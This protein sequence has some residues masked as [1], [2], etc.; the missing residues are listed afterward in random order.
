MSRRINARRLKVLLLGLWAVGVFVALGQTLVLAYK[1][2][3]RDEER[4]QAAQQHQRWRECAESAGG[5]REAELQCELEKESR[6]GFFECTS[7]NPYALGCLTPDI[8]RCIE[9]AFPKC[10][11]HLPLAWNAR[12][13]MPLR[14]RLAGIYPRFVASSAFQDFLFLLIGVPV[15]VLVVVPGIF[16]LCSWGGPRVMQWLTTTPDEG[17]RNAEKADSTTSVTSSAGSAATVGHVQ[18]ARPKTTGARIAA[19]VGAMLLI[20]LAL[21]IGSTAG[22]LGADAI[23][24]QRSQSLP[25]QLKRVAEEANSGLPMMIN[26]NTRLNRVIAG[27]GNRIAYQYTLMGV[28][29]GELGAEAIAERSTMITSE[30]CSRS[31]RQM[32]EHG[33]IMEYR[34]FASDGRSVARFDV[35]LA[36]CLSRPNE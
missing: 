3:D 8:E 33:V 32:L 14:E 35:S 24:P 30:V 34:Y 26:A 7:S 5:L 20:V 2:A 9:L 6:T 36:D 19:T 22:R 12:E 10:S 13:S 25:E 29:A 23:V 1:Y 4:W 18:K 27:P 21:V 28:G 31:G 15:I 11:E 16:R 17:A